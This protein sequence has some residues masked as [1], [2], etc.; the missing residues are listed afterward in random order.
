MPFLGCF[1]DFKYLFFNQ[2]FSQLPKPLNLHSLTHRLQIDTKKK[3]NG[4]TNGMPDER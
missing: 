1:K 3:K 2:I 4:I